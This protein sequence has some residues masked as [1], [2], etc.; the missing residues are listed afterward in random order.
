MET[1]KIFR[2]DHGTEGTFGALTIDGMAFCVTLERMWLNNEPNISCIPAGMYRC[3]R[4]RSPKFGTTFQ[5]TGVP[6]R[7]HILFH[8]GNEERHTKGCILLGASYAKLSASDRG[9]ANSGLT[10]Q[11]FMEAMVGVKEFALQ[12][13]EV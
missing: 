5:V 8:A 9:I 4:V 11:Q 7:G 2:I 13:V 10:F 1:V 6:G 12:I 3:Q